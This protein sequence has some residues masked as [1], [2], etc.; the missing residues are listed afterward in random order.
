LELQQQVR[1]SLTVGPQL[2][3]SDPEDGIDLIL[4]FQLI[5]KLSS[6]G[7]RIHFIG[8]TS[9]GVSTASA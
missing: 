5:D 1:I 6:G 9:D 7:F 2:P 3:I 8:E 4:W